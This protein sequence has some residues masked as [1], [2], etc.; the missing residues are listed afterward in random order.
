MFK[1]IGSILGLM[2]NLPKMKEEMEKLQQRVG[3]I[4]AEGAAGGGMVTV[5]LNGKREVVRCVISDDAWKM[6]DKELLEDLLK[7]AVN[8]AMERIKVQ[9]AQETAKFSSDVGLPMGGMGGLDSLLG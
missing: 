6:Q 4:T 9:V 5:T 7:G 1:D 8:N 3:Q 2:K